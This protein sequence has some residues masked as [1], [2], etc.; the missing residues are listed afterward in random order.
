MHLKTRQAFRFQGEGFLLMCRKDTEF[1]KPHSYVYQERSSEIYLQVYV[2][3]YKSQFTICLSRRIRAYSVHRRVKQQ[4][5]F[6]L[7]SHLTL[8]QSDIVGTRYRRWLRHYATSR[9]VSGSNP[10]EVDFFN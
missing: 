9:N 5:F 1:Q 8:L 7:F 2:S 10:D 4:L 6:I 3:A